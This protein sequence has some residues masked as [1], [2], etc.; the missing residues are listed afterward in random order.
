MFEVLLSFFAISM[1]VS[2]ASGYYDAKA[3]D[4]TKRTKKK[5]RGVV[6]RE[7]ANGRKWQSAGTERRPAITKT[8]RPKKRK[9]PKLSQWDQVELD[10]YFF[11]RDNPGS[12]TPESNIPL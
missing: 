6:R 11:R 4:K 8:R 2:I 3:K 7:R 1:L 9:R 5:G 10:L 12:K